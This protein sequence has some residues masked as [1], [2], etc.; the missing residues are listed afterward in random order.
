MNKLFTFLASAALVGSL[1]ACSSD[2]PAKGPDQGTTPEDGTTM[3]LN[4]NI[5]DANSMSRTDDEEGD[6]VAGTPFEHDIQTAHFFFFDKDGMFV[7]QANIWTGPDGVTT[8]DEYQDETNKKNPNIELKGNNVLV[9]KNLTKNNLPKYLIT[10]LNAPQELLDYVK[11]DTAPHSMDEF[12]TKTMDCRMD[13]KFFTMSTSSFYGNPTNDANRHE[14]AKYY[15]TVLQTT[16]FMKEP[17]ETVEANDPVVVVYVERLAAKYTIEGIDGNSFPVTINL[18]GEDNGQV[19]GNNN[20][21][22]GSTTPSTGIAGTEVYVTIKNIGVTGVEEV[23]F[24]SKNIDKFSSTLTPW[25]GDPVWNIDDLHRSYWA[26]SP[27]YDDAAGLTYTKFNEV[28][29]EV[30]KAVYSNE[31]TK[32]YTLIRDANNVLDPSKVTNVIFTATVSSDKEGKTPLDLILFSGVYYNTDR[33]IPYI[34]NRLN[35]VSKDNLNFYKY[36][37]TETNPETD[38]DEKHF[39]QVS[40]ADVAI[41]KDSE[42]GTGA[43]KFQSTVNETLYKKVETKNEDGTI[44]ISFTKLEGADGNTKFEERINSYFAQETPTKYTGGKMFYSIPVEHLLSPNGI[45][46]VSSNGQ[47]GV[48]RNHWYQISVNKIMNLG[49][50]VFDPNEEL[51]PDT[52]KKESFAMAASIKILSWKIV[53]QSVDL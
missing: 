19:N 2:E 16:D 3:Y 10:V 31:T 36:T 15:A 32:D 52:S 49:H 7:T 45:T 23:S 40:A 30:G 38:K 25:T 39:A 6:L 5:T 4:V 14:D 44:D 1:T 21:T 18:V 11:D 26:Q 35:L 51:V 17:K 48:V 37:G 43:I 34:L 47:W 53:K 28:N 13:G 12:R 20:N 29:G 24:L 42:K 50:G 27:K 22:E 33:F 8:P 41:I 9:L 46:T